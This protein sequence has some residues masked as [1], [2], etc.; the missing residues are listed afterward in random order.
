MFRFIPPATS[1]PSD[2]KLNMMP[3]HKKTFSNVLNR[4]AIQI[5]SERNHHSDSRE[6]RP[7]FSL[8]LFYLSSWQS[9]VS[10]DWQRVT[11]ILHTNIK[12]ILF[13]LT[14]RYA[15]LKW[16]QQERVLSFPYQRMMNWDHLCQIDY[17][18]IYDHFLALISWYCREE[19]KIHNRHT[20][21]KCLTWQWWA[22]R[23]HDV[24]DDKNITE[25]ED[26]ATEVPKSF[27][28]FWTRGLALSVAEFFFVLHYAFSSQCQRVRVFSKLKS[29]NNLL[30][31]RLAFDIYSTDV[32]ILTPA[33]W[34]Y[35]LILHINLLRKIHSSRTG[36]IASRQIHWKDSWA[37]TINREDP[38]CLKM[39]FLHAEAL[40]VIKIY[41][42]WRNSE[43]AEQRPVSSCS[44]R[45]MSNLFLSRTIN[46]IFCDTLFDEILS[47]VA[48][49][50]NMKTPQIWNEL[51]SHI[52]ISVVKQHE[53]DCSFHLR[54]DLK[55]YRQWG[56]KIG[57]SCVSLF[58]CAFV[59]YS[60]WWTK[61][62]KR[63]AAIL[64]YFI[65]CR[66]KIV[67]WLSCH[68]LLRR[69]QQK[70]IKEREVSDRGGNLSRHCGEHNWKWA[71]MAIPH[72]TMWLRPWE[73]GALPKQQVLDA[74]ITC[75][76]QQ[77]GQ[78]SY[79]YPRGGTELSWERQRVQ[80]EH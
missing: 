31:R 60:L 16:F 41:F 45:Q 30:I 5:S 78:A 11:P 6:T 32:M 63:I 50:P 12:S 62:E 36:S 61:L 1:F 49:I 15:R 69:F 79:K 27:R 37:L 25:P 14:W 66:G 4:E 51:I 9:R 55:E 46:L 13:T 58:L 22:Q 43:F 71:G 21:K 33:Y 2:T 26:E 52:Q 72:T 56:S 8:A 35:S 24:K 77:A 54:M 34:L 59:R 57:T 80:V 75:S 73:E 65:Y 44:G 70:K 47:R 29:Q 10:M 42:I 53:C 23:R 48:Q 19:D 68:M 28:K 3:A 74:A 38:A 7:I 39:G 64:F 18:R 67:M 20:T 40:R 17:P 76:K